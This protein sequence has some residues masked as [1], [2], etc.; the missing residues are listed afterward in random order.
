MCVRM[1]VYT[2]MYMY[3]C[4]YVSF[5]F[6]VELWVRL[7]GVCI[8]GLICMHSSAERVFNAQTRLHTYIHTYIHILE[9]LSQLEKI[10]TT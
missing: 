8:L 1:C 9:G 2:C 10:Y 5:G 7:T 4:M 6:C 3:V